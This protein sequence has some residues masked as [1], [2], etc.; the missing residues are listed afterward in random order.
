MP[1]QI[2]WSGAG[3]NRRPS[4]FQWE[5]DCVRGIQGGHRRFVVPLCCAGKGRLVAF[6]MGLPVDAG[7]EEILVVEVDRSEVAEDLVLASEPGKM[8]ARAQVTLGGPSESIGRTRSSAGAPAD[9]RG[10]GGRR[11]EHGRPHPCGCVLR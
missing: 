8:T 3:S 6:L 10:L 9:R 4:A 2:E 5:N 11:V 1:V 7:S